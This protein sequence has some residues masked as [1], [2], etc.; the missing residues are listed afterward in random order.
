MSRPLLP[1]KTSIFCNMS[2]PWLLAKTLGNLNPV[3][4]RCG[5][6]ALFMSANICDVLWDLILSEAFE[7]VK[8]NTITL[9]YRR[10]KQSIV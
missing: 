2:K 3:L 6:T 10:G 4:R 9:V 7:V 1:E 5:I 8:V